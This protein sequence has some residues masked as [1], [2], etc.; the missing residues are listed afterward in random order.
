[1]RDLEIEREFDMEHYLFDFLENDEIDLLLEC[2]GGWWQEER[3]GAFTYSN[4]EIQVLKGLPKREYL[5]ENEYS[6]W[7]MMCDIVFAFLYEH[8]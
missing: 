5:V 3:Q 2:K 8:T 6:I 4:E 7:A 1:M